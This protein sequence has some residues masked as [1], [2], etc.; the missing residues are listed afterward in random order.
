MSE[1]GKIHPLPLGEGAAAKREPDRAKPQLKRRVW[2][3]G[4][5]KTCDS[6]PA[7]FSAAARSQ[8]GR[9]RG[10]NDVDDAIQVLLAQ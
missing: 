9:V 1:T 5:A 7:A 8:R 10:S 4:F 6:H 3:S 2:V